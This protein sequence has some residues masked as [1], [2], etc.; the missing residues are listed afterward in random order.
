MVK[1]GEKK[2]KLP[3]QLFG[4]KN[5][6]TKGR[7]D[8]KRVRG[9]QRRCEVTKAK[10]KEVIIELLEDSSKKKKTKELLRC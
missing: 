3:P 2:N 7:E 6:L 10:N 8:N 4:N 5:L 1:T 9:S